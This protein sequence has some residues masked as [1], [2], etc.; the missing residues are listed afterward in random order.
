MQKNHPEGVDITSRYPALMKGL[1]FFLP[2][3]LKKKILDGLL[4][5]LCM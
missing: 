2:K 3:F 5:V 1:P 4:M